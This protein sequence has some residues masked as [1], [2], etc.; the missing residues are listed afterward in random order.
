MTGNGISKLDLKRQNRMQILRLLR[1]SGPTSRIDIA[2]DIGITKAAVTVITNE[3]IKQGCLYEKGEQAPRGAKLPRGRKKILLDISPTYKMD[4]G[5]VLEGDVL[6][7]G[8]CT[9]HGEP[10]EKHTVSIPAEETADEVLTRIETIYRDLLYKNDLTPGQITGL[11]VCVDETLGESFGTV[12]LGK[13]LEE[14][15]SLP[16][17]FGSI[18]E[19]AALAE[20][21]YWQPAGEPAG[22]LLAFRCGDV[23]TCAL[24]LGAELRRGVHER[25]A[26]MPESTGVAA[27]LARC[28][29]LFSQEATPELWVAA[30]GNPGRILPELRRSDAPPLDPPIRDL[31]AGFLETRLQAILDAVRLLDPGR[32]VLLEDGVPGSDA[33]FDRLAAAAEEQLGELGYPVVRSRIWGS[34][35]FLA[36]AALAAREFFLNRGGI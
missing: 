33:L 3:M 23:L 27:L 21:D 31:V 13:R 16:M 29:D 4:M 30:G 2:R 15:I 20:C 5:L 22:E 26:S 18:A 19:G 12:S 6:S 34:D 11:G 8:I 32:V 25:A 35:R 14:V 9:L 36:G 28:R 10:V 7:F 1:D 24:V 17:A